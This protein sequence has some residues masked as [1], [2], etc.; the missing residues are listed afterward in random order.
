MKL[1]VVKMSSLGDVV[2][3]LPAVTDLLAARPDVVIDW[4][5]EEGFQAIPAFHPGVRRVIPIAIRRW[6]SNWWRFRREV[7][8]FLKALKHEQYDVILDAQGLYKSALVAALAQGKVEGFDRASAR[9]P[10]ATLGYQAH[11]GVARELHAVE[12]QRQLF[13]KTFNYPV[14]NHLDYGLGGDN[15]PASKDI[16]F[17]HGTTWA[18]KHWPEASWIALAKLCDSAGYRVVL[19]FLGDEEQARATTIVKQTNNAVLLAAGS[20]QELGQ[21]LAGAHAAVSVDTGLGH[22]AA[23]FNVPL[24]AL[25]G[26]TSPK[27]TGAIGPRQISL[28]DTDL[29]CAPCM[30]RACKYA[31]DSSK[32]HPP[33]FERLTAER[34]FSNLME[35]LRV[36]G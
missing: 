7:N 13:A 20:L 22:L 35:Q 14:P 32:I 9:E 36:H 2:H 12:R 28:A 31:A 27:L 11:H 34:V 10:L 18:S 3:C 33:C 25:Y 24:V 1:L 21:H 30:N 17:F 26:P 6:R 4:V 16:F 15:P 8:E 23:A 29:T 19:P 5:V